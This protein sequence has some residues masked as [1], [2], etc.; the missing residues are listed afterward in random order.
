MNRLPLFFGLFR[1]VFSGKNTRRFFFLPLIVTALMIGDGQLLAQSQLYDLYVSSS[2]TNSVKLYDGETGAYIKDF[3]APSAGGLANTQEVVFGPDGH[4]YVTGFGNNR[5][6]K[7]DGQSGEFIE[8]FSKNYSLSSPAKMTF[9]YEDGLI[10]VSQWNGNRKV[11]RFRIDDGEFVDEFTSVGVP[12]NCGFAWDP[13]GNLYVTGWG[14]NGND[15]LVQKFDTT[16]VLM[17]TFISTSDIAGPVNCWFGENGDLFVQDW[18]RGN[19]ERFSA[20]GTSLGTY[21]NNL[22]RTEGYDWDE[23]GDLYLCDWFQDRINRYDPQGNFLGIFA[24]GGGLDTPNGLVFGPKYMPV[25]IE[26]DDA[27]PQAFELSQ[28]YPNPFNPSTTVRFAIPEAARVS[29]ELYTVLGH[30]IS[31]VLDQQMTPGWHSINIDGSDLASGIYL[32]RIH[33]NDFSDVKKM[34]LMK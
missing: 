12:G 19:I 8:N 14:S 6:K 28:N 32:Y 21:I 9:R 16:G 4:L 10:Y 7:Y 23:H 5:I 27:L 1:E 11:V 33:A 20:D 25:G 18:T 3:V 26:D 24:D 2:V 13:D 29:I 15:G 34:I 17:Q 31:T 30:K 22:V